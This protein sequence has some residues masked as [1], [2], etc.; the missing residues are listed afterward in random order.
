MEGWHDRPPI[1]TLHLNSVRVHAHVERA[2][3]EAEDQQGHSE[4]PGL[5]GQ[6]GQYQGRAAQH[7][8]QG[9]DGARAEPVGQAAAQLHA[10]EGPHPQQHEESSEGRV[11]HTH[12]SLNGWDLHDPHAQQRAVE[13]EVDERHSTGDAQGFRAARPPAR[14]RWGLRARLV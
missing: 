7:T 8:G 10:T 5:L 13:D 14:V 4:D 2:V 6:S 1:G 3:A 11:A 9:D 12:A